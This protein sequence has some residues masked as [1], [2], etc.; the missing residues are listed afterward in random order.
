MS[1][2]HTESWQQMLHL[3][4]IYQ[5][6]TGRIDTSEDFS[7]WFW[8]NYLL[9]PDPVDTVVEMITHDIAGDGDEISIADAMRVTWE[10][11]RRILMADKAIRRASMFGGA[12]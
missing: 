8:N 2:R 5:L 6:Q 4:I 10:V 7:T 1:D 12:K 11:S 9:Y 3:H